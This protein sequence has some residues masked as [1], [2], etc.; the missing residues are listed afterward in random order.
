MKKVDSP[1]IENG[2]P[3]RASSSI[4]RASDLKRLKD[5]TLFLWYNIFMDMNEY[6]KQRYQKRRSEAII[7]LGSKCSKCGSCNDLHIHHKDPS[8]K[9]FTLAKGSSY[10]KQ[11]WDN[12][13]DKCKLLCEP[14]HITEHNSKAPCGTPQRYW[15]GC[16]CD[17]CKTANAKHN[18]EYKRLRA[19][20]Q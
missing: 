18:K 12:E 19:L 15:R 20:R 6:M 5:I 2:G 1:N 9:S 7:K 10:S 16:R 13:V 11:R 4:G 3:A 17:L 14:C 8:E